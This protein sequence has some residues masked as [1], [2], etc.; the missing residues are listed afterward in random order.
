MQGYKNVRIPLPPLATQE[1]IVREMENIE[2]MEIEALREVE[3]RQRDIE[4][5]IE[6]FELKVAIKNICELSRE[7]IDPQK[8]PFQLFNYVG[9]EHIGSNTGNLLKVE[10]MT[11]FKLKSAKNV[12]KK[13]DLLYGKLRPYL[14]KVY[15]AEFDG[16]CSTDILVIRT[17]RALILK[18]IL[19]GRWFVEKSTALMKGTNLPRLQVEEF[20]NFKVP[21]PD[22]AEVDA[23]SKSFV[24]LE[25]TQ[26]KL[27]VEIKD[28]ANDKE[29]LL[30]KH[31]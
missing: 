4:N 17:N 19:M 21:M 2:A 13:G 18:Q 11:G 30:L 28:L 16:V 10:Q 22:D 24:E 7:K 25:L 8:Y 9:L 3:A 6:K 5:I 23:I 29:A 26:N 12:F 15:I 27:K 31:L 1:Q 20:M 14:N